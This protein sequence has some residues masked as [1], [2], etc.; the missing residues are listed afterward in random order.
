MEN[1]G[2]IIIHDAVPN[3]KTPKI[4]NQNEIFVNLTE[5]GS[6]DKTI[7]EAAACECL[8]VVS[9]QSLKDML[10]EQFLFQDRSADELAEKLQIILSVAKK[11]K[12]EQGKILR[13]HVTPHNIITLA[14]S[15]FS[16]M[17]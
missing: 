12:E 6:F 7:L 8:V 9:N 13:Q 16:S 10:S 2:K 17:E 5:S 15:V 4:Y 1:K 3:H 11:N 14:N